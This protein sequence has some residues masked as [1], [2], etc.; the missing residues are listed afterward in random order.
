MASSDQTMSVDEK[1]KLI[2]RNLDE[3]LGED[4]LRKIVSER[5]L[6]IYW[7]TAT[8]GKPHIAYF[9]PMSKVADFLR[10]GCHVTILFADLHAYLDNM[11]APWEL[12][13]LRTEYYENII[14]SMLKSINVPLEKLKF[15]RGTDYQLKQDYTLDVYRL[16]SM[17]TEHD[18][19]KA[20]AEVVKQVDHPLLSGLL[21]PGLQALDEEYL[22]VDAQFG[23]VDQRK[24]FTYAEKYLPKLGYKKRIH[25]MNPMVP[26]LMGAKMSSSVADS[27]ID[28]LDSEG[29]V[30]KK[31][32]Q[33]FCEPGNIE[34]NGLLAFA[35]HVI[36]PLLGEKPFEVE[37]KQEYGGNIQFTVF[38]DLQ[39]A[40]KEEQIHP[41]DLKS[42]V[43]KYINEMLNP[44]RQEFQSKELKNLTS[45]AYPK[46]QPKAANEIEPSRLDLRIGKITEINMH[47]D[48]ESLYVEKV[49]LGNGEVRTVVSGLAGLVKMEDL[50]DS[51]G[52]FLCN[53]KPTKMRGVESS[54]MLLCASV[55][56]PERKVEA[57]I[58]PEN[59]Q[60]GDRV[61]FEKYE[62]GQPDER[63]NPKKKIWE[64]LAT[65]LVTNSDGEAEWKGNAMLTS[66]GKIS[67]KN[68]KN[69]PIK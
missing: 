23:G 4:Q 6:N 24:I 8:T 15:V 62:K 50:K 65:D 54:A 41:G 66:N 2:T 14:K 20:G 52:V 16:S 1:L 44:I 22:K 26:G 67:V 60:P 25:L 69:A 13:K 39:K 37:R 3:V 29:D 49:D 64:T 57:L 40:F 61:V 36:L 18:A 35:K 48:A 58:P 17:V 56:E 45:K 31:I 28:L 32:K 19:K 42:A 30:N 11:K 43:K 7:G 9:V 33:A 59:S 51:L 47:P 27:K 12:L 10:A 55:N 5:D 53:L 21:Y 34:N 63:L 38:E 68:L 46:E